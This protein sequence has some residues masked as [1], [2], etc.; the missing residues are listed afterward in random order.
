MIIGILQEKPDD[1]ILYDYLAVPYPEGYIGEVNNFLFF[2][3]DINDILFTGYENSER[4]VFMNAMHVLYD[5]MQEEK[6][7]SKQV[8]VNTD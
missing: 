1:Q 6:L 8:D 2:H 5:K 4:D 7:I 3:E